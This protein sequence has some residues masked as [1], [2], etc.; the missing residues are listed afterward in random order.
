M[1]DIKIAPKTDSKGS[2][3]QRKHAC[4]M[5]PINDI[6]GDRSGGYSYIRRG[7]EY[8]SYTKNKHHDVSTDDTLVHKPSRRNHITSQKPNTLKNPSNTTPAVG[9]IMNEISVG[10]SMSHEERRLLG[11]NHVQ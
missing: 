9:L 1:V 4:Y 10:Q 5:Y 6:Y 7:K 8:L 2:T 3:T 11:N